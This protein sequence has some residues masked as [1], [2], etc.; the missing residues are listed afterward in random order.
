VLTQAATEAAANI[1]KIMRG[2]MCASPE[3]HRISL[4]SP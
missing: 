4:F 3:N 1:P 2:S